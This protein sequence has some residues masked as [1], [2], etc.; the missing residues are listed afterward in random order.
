MAWWTG[1]SAESHRGR[2]FRGVLLRVYEPYLLRGTPGEH[3]GE[4]LVQLAGEPVGENGSQAFA[5]RP[6]LHADRRLRR[7]FGTTCRDKYSMDLWKDR[8]ELAGVLVPVELGWLPTFGDGLKG[9]YKFGA[10]YNSSTAPNVVENTYGQP[11]AIDGG[12]PLIRHGQY[13]AYANFLQRLTTPSDV[14]SRPL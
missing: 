3:R 7:Q 9:S 8:A 4:L 1:R 5:Q 10:C 12:Q 2:G 14:R 6:R 13:G 11:L